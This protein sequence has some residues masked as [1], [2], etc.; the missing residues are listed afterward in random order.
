MRPYTGVI[1][2]LITSLLLSTLVS[3][4]ETPEEILA[5]L[6]SRSHDEGWTFSVDENGATDRSIDDLCGLVAPEGWRDDARFDP[7][8]PQRD[9][10]TSFDWR[11]YNG[12]TP[13]RN[14]GSCGSCWAFS[15][16]GAL[17]CNIKIKDGISKD[18][19]EQWLVSCNSDGYDCGGGWF[20]H[21]YHISVSYTHLRAHET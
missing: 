4:G 21:D 18:L 12:C 19:S 17:E 16:V 10:P 1:A 2:L 11:D 15:T 6:R 3:A 13:I 14:Q 7:C 8:I 9:L 5:T 20:V